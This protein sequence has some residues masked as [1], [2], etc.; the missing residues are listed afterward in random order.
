[1]LIIQK[2]EEE[3]RNNILIFGTSRSGKTKLSM[4]INKRFNYNAIATDS[5]VSAFEKSLPELNINKHNADRATVLR[6]KPFLDAYMN[7]L[8]NYNNRQRDY[9]YVVEGCYLDLLSYKD[10]YKYVKIVLVQDLPSYKDYYERLIKYDKSCDWTAQISKDQLIEYCKNLKRENDRFIAYCKQNNIKYYNTADDR[11]SVFETILN[12]LQDSI[13]R[14]KD[15]FLETVRIHYGSLTINV[16]AP[17]S[18]TNSLL[19]RFAGVVTYDYRFKENKDYTIKFLY[20]IDNIDLETLHCTPEGLD[21]EVEFKIDNDKKECYVFLDR[22]LEKQ[23]KKQLIHKMFN[24]IALRLFQLKKAVFLH[25]ACVEKNNNIVIISGNP[26]SGKTVTLLNLLDAGFNYITNDFLII[27]Y[28]DDKIQF[29][30][31]SKYIGIRKT[32]KWLEIPSMNEKYAGLKTERKIVVKD[33]YIMMPPE[34][35]VELNEVNFG[36]SGGELKL[37][38]FPKYKPGERFESKDKAMDDV[39][40]EI[41]YQLL[42]NFLRYNNDSLD[43]KP[44]DIYKINVDVGEQIDND[45]IFNTIYNANAFDISQNENTIQEYVNFINNKLKD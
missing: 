26:F 3:V 28:F 37:L 33:D 16:E 41:D 22:K 35:L 17:G 27:D 34:K 40:Q 39:K 12:D 20:S 13:F 24:M 25:C 45:L 30:P 4:L 19:R 1:M 29:L 23:I 44:F 6:L 11:D 7:S 42:F 9:N 14:D 2:V 43:S 36:N 8:N 15:D 38:V 18:L 10:Y 31:S 21:V 32:K 5:I